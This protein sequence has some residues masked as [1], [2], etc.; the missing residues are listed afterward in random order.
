MEDLQIISALQFH[1]QHLPFKKAEIY[2][3]IQK[4]EKSM[5]LGY[6]YCIKRD[7]IE[8]TLTKVLNFK[9]KGIKESIKKFLCTYC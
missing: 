1:L 8:I 9:K 6:T 2:L 4:T 3:R 5:A 7:Y